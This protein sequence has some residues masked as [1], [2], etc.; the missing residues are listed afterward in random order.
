MAAAKAEGKPA[1][2][3]MAAITTSHAVAEATS[4]KAAGPYLTSVFNPAFFNSA[5]NAA[6]AS[7]EPT[8]TH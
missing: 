5:V 2:P 1:A 4:H 7:A 3:T 8:T 6:A